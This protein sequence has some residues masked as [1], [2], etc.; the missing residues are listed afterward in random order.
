[1]TPM[2]SA[3]PRRPTRIAFAVA[4]A[5]A[6]LAALAAQV[7]LLAAPPALQAQTA[8]DPAS[9]VSFVL[10]TTSNCML[11][12][13]Q[14]VQVKNTHPGRTVRVWLDRMQ[15]GIGTGDRSRSELRSGAE[16]EPLG[17][18]R[19]AAGVQEWRIVRAVFVD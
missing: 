16:P 2:T 17:C 9:Y 1:M 10:E 7:A 11:N 19:S 8:D 5:V 18:S 4:N 13:G 15:A 3:M 6:A 12:H 14:Q